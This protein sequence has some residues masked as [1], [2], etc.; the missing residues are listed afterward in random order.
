MLVPGAN[1]AICS[2]TNDPG[3]WSEGIYGAFGQGKNDPPCQGYGIF[4]VLTNP[5]RI[6]MKVNDADGKQKLS[7]RYFLNPSDAL[8][9]G[10]LLQD[11]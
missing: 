2:T 4:R 1:L 3:V 10:S 8:K 11:Q 7:L 6:I 5:D 9:Y